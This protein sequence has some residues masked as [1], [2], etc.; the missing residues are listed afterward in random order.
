ML[1]P[2]KLTI[3]IVAFH[4]DFVLLDRCLKSIARHCKLEQIESIKII[5]NDLPIYLKP[6][7]DIVSKVKKLPIEV[8]PS[9]RLEPVITEYFN[10]NTQQ[11]FKILS[12]ELV[13]T[14][15]YLIHDCKDYYTAPVDFFKDCFTEDGRAITKLDH[16]QYSDYN[17]HGG[18]FLPF[19]LAYEVACNVW[20][21]SR[22]DTA[23]W[24]LPTTT[25]FFVKT[26]M[27]KGMVTEL[28]SMIRGFLPY[29]FNLA[30]NEERFATEFLM[31]SAYC[32]NK[33]KLSDYADWSVNTVYYSKFKQSKDLRV[34]FPSNPLMN[35]KFFHGGK[36]WQFTGSTWEPSLETSPPAIKEDTDE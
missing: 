9:A 28:R 24:H 3:V 1:E 29:L 12:H 20:K 5:L 19:N 30:I 23:I 25:P 22:Q 10:W 33:N 4:S 16:T 7:H 11:L 18:G 35:E 31:Y 21:V 17:K 6:L 36:I 26:S 34:H 8:V 32:F 15:W 2:K 13:T 27:M 14:E